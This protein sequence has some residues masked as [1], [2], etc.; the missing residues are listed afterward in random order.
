MNSGVEEE[1]TEFELKT[2]EEVPDGPAT[3]HL[4]KQK[5]SLM[6]D[7]SLLSSAGNNDDDD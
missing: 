3:H 7:E 6:K 4:I 5:T 2:K 1:K